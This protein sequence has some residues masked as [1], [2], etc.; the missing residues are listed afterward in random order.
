[1]VIRRG[2]VW[3]ADLEDPRGSE[4]GSSRPV[5]IV[6]ADSFNRSAIRTVIAVTLSTNPALAEMPGNVRIQATASGL[7]RDSVANVTQIVTIDRAFLRDR[8]SKLPKRILSEI[9]SGLLLVLSL[10]GL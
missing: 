7:P 9:D 5:V 8:V 3:W 6:Q 10:S 2:E 4:P 1:M